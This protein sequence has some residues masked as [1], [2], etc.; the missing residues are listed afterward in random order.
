[1]K[2]ICKTHIHTNNL[3]F[4]TDCGIPNRG[5]DQ[6]KIDGSPTDIGEYPWQVS[7][8]KIQHFVQMSTFITISGC[9]IATL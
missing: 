1:M 8:L 6:P 7:G 3:V 4:F 9:N 5:D 2:R